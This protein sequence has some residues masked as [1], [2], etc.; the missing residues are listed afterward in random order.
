LHCKVFLRFFPDFVLI[1]LEQL[2]IQPDNNDDMH[3]S[4]KAAMVYAYDRESAAD[5]GAADRVRQPAIT[6]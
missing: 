6:P 1:H 5:P 3:I 2:R 4:D